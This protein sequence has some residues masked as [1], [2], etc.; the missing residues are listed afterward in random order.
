M[1]AKG[2]ADLA[3]R[4]VPMPYNEMVILHVFQAI[5]RHHYLRKHYRDLLNPKKTKKPYTIDTL[6]QQIA[7]AVRQLVLA[8][9]P[10][11]K[12]RVDTDE[13]ALLV[14]SVSRLRNIK[15]LY[16]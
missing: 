12:D 7:K 3:L 2:L 13:Q 1:R 5:E 11:A 4:I 9:K 15:R 16:Y 10:K 6:N 8:D 14:G